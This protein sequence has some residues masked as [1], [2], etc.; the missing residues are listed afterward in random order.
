MERFFQFF[1]ADGNTLLQPLT[2]FFV[3]QLA[4][5]RGLELFR[6]H[7][8]V[9]QHLQVTG[10]VKDT[11][12]L[13]GVI[14]GNRRD[15]LVLAHLEPQPVRFLHQQQLVHQ[16]PHCLQRQVQ[17][18]FDF[19]V[20]VP[21]VDALIQVVQVAVTALESSVADFVIVDPGR[22]ICRL[23]R[24]AG[25]GRRGEHGVADDKTEND[26]T[27][28][29]LDQDRFLLGSNKVKHCR[30]LLDFLDVNGCET[31]THIRPANRSKA[32]IFSRISPC[33]MMVGLLE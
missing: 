32:I 29:D 28:C 9:V 20:E 4:F 5:L 25:V 17:L 21:L 3:Q 1:F 18:L 27:E 2:H 7:P 23:A 6:S 13:K 11:I 33:L 31:A 16:L 10:P 30:E 26:Q 24:R 22:N 8:L 12:F 15:Q 14:L 19:V